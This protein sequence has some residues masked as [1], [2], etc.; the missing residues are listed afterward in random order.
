VLTAA[1]I[2]AGVDSG[3]EPKPEPE[4]EPEPKPEP[5]PEPEP[6]AEAKTGRVV[7]VYVDDAG[8]EHEVGEDELDDFEVVDEDDEEDKP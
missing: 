5:E 1:D 7:Y 3:S 8:V 2:L 4:P 6:E